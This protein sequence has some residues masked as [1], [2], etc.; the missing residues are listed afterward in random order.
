MLTG[1]NRSHLSLRLIEDA[2]LVTVRVI[3]KSLVVSDFGNMVL[4][5][6]FS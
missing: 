1:S 6:C 2:S 3:R 4:F 5:I